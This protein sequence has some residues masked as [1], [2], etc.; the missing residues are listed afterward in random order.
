MQQIAAEEFM[1]PLEHLR[2]RDVPK[3]TKHSGGERGKRNAE[4][5]SATGSEGLF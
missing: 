4:L 5:L 2:S 3:E 1:V